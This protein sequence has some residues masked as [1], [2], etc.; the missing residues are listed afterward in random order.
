MKLAIIGA[1]G[2]L[3]TELVRE[4]LGRGCETVAVCRDG[5]AGKLGA[6]A[7]QDGYKGVAA[8][9]VSDAAMLT[10]ALTGC[11]AVAAISISV[12]RLKA[13]ELVD[14]LVRATGAN[15]ITRVVFSAGEVTAVPEPG[16]KFTIR[17][18]MMK[19]AGL[20]ISM[21][22][23]YSMADMIAASETVR[24]QTQWKWNIV[25]APTL[26]DA[27]PA[28][29]RYCGLWEITSTHSLA[30]KDYAAALIDTLADPESPRRALTVTA[31]DKTAPS[32]MIVDHARRGL[33]HDAGRRGI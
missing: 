8:P 4:A 29:Y 19:A 14:S 24:R 13:T 15:G 22:T 5:S 26:V 21:V 27:A 2:K 11:D 23:P 10:R 20:L 17:Q 1:C 31:L 9:V 33:K 6:F 32:P 7:G 16:E 28:G 18:R 12:G 25:R 30:R 3:G